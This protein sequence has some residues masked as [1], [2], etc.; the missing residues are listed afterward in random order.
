LRILT[1]NDVDFDCSSVN[2]HFENRDLH[3]VTRALRS[4]L[5]DDVCDVYVEYVKESLQSP[6]Q[7]A[8][9]PSLLFLHSAL[10]SSLKMLHPL[11]PFL[12]EELY[13]RLP[14]LPN[15][16]RQE[17][18]MIDA[19]P[20]ALEWNGFKNDHLARSVRAALSVTRSVRSLR[21]SYELV[22]EAR[23]AV[24][25]CLN[26]EEEEGGV[27]AE[28]LDQLA[29]VISCLGRCGPVRFVSHVI[30]RNFSLCFEVLSVTLS[31]LY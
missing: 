4:F 3:H 2:E 10:I 28:E 20:Q 14:R 29:D 27:R 16:R 19:Y 12:T 24:T 23:P 18:V 8:F 13:Q 31:Y 6:D 15:E 11:M 26:E 1:E 21:A 30:G 22:K 5:Y 9:L 7:P 17:C 25:V